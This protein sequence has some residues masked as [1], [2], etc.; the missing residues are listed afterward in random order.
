MKTARQGQFA[1]LGAALLF[2]CSAPLVSTL[3]GSG[4]ALLTVRLVRGTQE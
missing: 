2:G 1:G 3:T 4:S